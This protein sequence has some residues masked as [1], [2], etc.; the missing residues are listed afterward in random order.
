MCK[1]VYYCAYVCILVQSAKVSFCGYLC[2]IN[3]LKHSL[4]SKFYFKS[5]PFS[6]KASFVKDG[7]MKKKEKRHEHQKEMKTRL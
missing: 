5:A 7:F 6:M 1:H 2:N 4:E 3:A